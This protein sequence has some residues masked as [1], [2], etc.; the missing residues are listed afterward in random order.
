MSYKRIIALCL[1]LTALTGGL[2]LLTSNALEDPKESSIAGGSINKSI[3]A[4][5]SEL[6][7]LLRPTG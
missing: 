7:G 2:L 1:A 4:I 5:A 3:P 6:I